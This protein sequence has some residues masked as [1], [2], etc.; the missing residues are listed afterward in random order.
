MDVIDGDRRG[1]IQPKVLDVF[2]ILY[3]MFVK[4]SEKIVEVFEFVVILVVNTEP[5]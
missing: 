4:R 2:L 5:N 3:F 1:G